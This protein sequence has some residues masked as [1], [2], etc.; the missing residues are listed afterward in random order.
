MVSLIERSNELEL[1]DADQI[2]RE[3][4][5]R[6]L[7]ELHVINKLLGGYNVVFQGIERLKEK[8]NKPL[9]ILD[10]GSGG[11]DT[12]KEIYKKYHNK[13]ELEL[14]G[15]D[16]KEDC[17]N[18]SQKNCSGL[19]I[20]FVQSD[21]RDFL[22]QE[23]Q[24][25]IIICSLFCHHLKDEDLVQLFQTINKSA[26]AGC[27]IN[28]LQRHFLAYYSIKWLTKYLSKSYLV[29]NDACLSVARSF[30]KKDIEGLMQ[31]ASI[32]TYSLK[33]QWAFRWLLTF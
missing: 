2:P 13:F 14:V 6:N 23:Q 31:K 7:Y 24:F 22:Q 17:I 27:I 29:K 12:L 15:V 20:Q 21:Y 26:K 19:P 4:L 10:I 8:K 25:D 16:L 1:L 18:Y 28:D 32:D 11:G 33:W 5:Y 3:D 9:R 30:S